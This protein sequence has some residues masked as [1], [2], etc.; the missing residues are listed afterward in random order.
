MRTVFGA[1]LLA[2]LTLA[3]AGRAENLGY[4]AQDLLSTQ[5]DVLGR[6]ITYPS[7]PAKVS[8]AIVTIKPG[9][10]G[11]LHRHQIPM[12]AYVLQ[13][14]I[15][16]DYGPHGTRTF[17]KGDALVEAQEVPHRGM[18]KGSEPVALLV[19][20]IGAEGVA[21]VVPVE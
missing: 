21:S 18:N 7:G 17:R 15:T 19:V 11:Q 10:S 20:Y 3:T 8:S 4:P 5:A 16:V 9:E 2:C 12:Y 1:A 6:G 14:E 13:G